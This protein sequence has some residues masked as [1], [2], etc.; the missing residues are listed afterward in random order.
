MPKLPAAAT[1]IFEYVLSAMMKMPT[2]M[3]NAPTAPIL[4]GTGEPLPESP[5]APQVPMEEEGTLFA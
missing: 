3:S 4:P 5:G 1:R 2:I